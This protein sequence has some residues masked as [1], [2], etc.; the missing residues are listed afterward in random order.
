[1]LLLYLHFADYLLILGHSIFQFSQN[2]EKYARQREQTQI[3]WFKGQ[4]ILLN[5]V[6]IAYS[7]HKH[8]NTEDVNMY[9]YFEVYFSFLCFC[10][11]KF[12]LFKLAHDWCYI[13]S[14]GLNK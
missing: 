12:D 6:S 9:L 13:L 5:N 11:F 1:M 10:N 8:S 7:I 14:K 3:C 4:S 2:Q